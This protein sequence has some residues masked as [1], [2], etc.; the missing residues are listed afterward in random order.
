MRV[1]LIASIDR[2]CVCVRESGSSA[3]YV[4]RKPIGG[5]TIAGNGVCEY[6]KKHK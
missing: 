1:C 3:R 2:V 6:F 5:V 4:V